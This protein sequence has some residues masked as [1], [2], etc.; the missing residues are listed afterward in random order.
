MSPS[1]ADAVLTFRTARH[2]ILGEQVLLAAGERVRVMPLPARITAG[3][4]I[5]LRVPAARRG[6]A[7]AALAG[8]GAPAEGI[9]L[10]APDGGY[11]LFPA[12]VFSEALG[13]GAGDAVAIVGCGGKTA[14]ANRLATENRHLPVLFSTTTRIFAPPEDILSGVNFAC[15][16]DDSGAKLR[17]IDADEL[18]RLRP[19]GGVTLLEADGSRGLALKGWADH[20]PVVPG[21]VTVTAGVCALWP[22]GRAFRTEETH[23]AE[24]FCAATGLCEGD[25]VTVEHIA[26]MVG[27][28][29]RK[30]V[31]RRV[32]FVNQLETPESESVARELTARVGTMR[33]AAGSVRDGVARV[34]REG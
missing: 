30:A 4:G 7:A 18:E 17:G 23:R 2:A 26:A 29:F 20:E 15:V 14:L 31:G 9:F 22:V 24:L 10:R 11:R 32:L 25:V 27:E 16:P 5:C 12:P 1:D 21:F 6:A 19:A 28:M 33:V 34:L 3:C 8:G 13:I